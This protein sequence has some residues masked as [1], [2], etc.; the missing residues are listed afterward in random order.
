MA[1]IIGKLDENGSFQPVQAQAPEKK[2]AQ[3]QNQIGVDTTEHEFRH[4]PST[5][6]RHHGTNENT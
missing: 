2:E 6:E 5:F 4:R 1:A 3:E